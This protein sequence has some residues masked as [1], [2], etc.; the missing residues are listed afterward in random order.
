VKYLDV[1]FAKR[2]NRLPRLR[3]SQFT[4]SSTRVLS[5]VF[6]AAVIFVIGYAYIVLRI[7]GHQATLLQAQANALQQ[8]MAVHKADE[9]RVSTEIAQLN[10]AYA[11]RQV[12]G[13]I[14]RRMTTLI[15]RMNPALG[16]QS[17][18]I[19][20][21]QDTGHPTITF[22]GDSKDPRAGDQL[23]AMLNNVADYNDTEG[24]QGV[25]VFT[26]GAEPKS[27]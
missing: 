18:T 12:N 19:A 14:A 5:G 3:L 23:Y 24:E 15:Q 7:E 20:M 27:Q 21:D 17:M 10:N 9:T 13:I 11:A 8:Q 25:H 6:V 16:L 2:A 1:N 4:A 22:G 26:I